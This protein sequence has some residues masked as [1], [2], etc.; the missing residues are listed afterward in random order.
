MANRSAWKCLPF[1]SAFWR[2]KCKCLRPARVVFALLSIFFAG[3][4]A[5]AYD[6]LQAKGNF[7][8]DIVD[9]LT[10]YQMSAGNAE[11]MNRLDVAAQLDKSKDFALQ[12]LLAL[13]PEASEY[14]K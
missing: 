1:V 2:T 7:S 10:Y 6:F 14:R 5:E 8:N 13:R 11:Q 4:S 9:C 3:T 12:M